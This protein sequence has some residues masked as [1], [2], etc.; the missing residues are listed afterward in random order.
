MKGS[1]SSHPQMC[2][3]ALGSWPCRGQHW[4]GGGE[5]M[6]RWPPGSPL[7]LDGVAAWACPS[8][9]TESNG[10]RVAPRLVRR[11]ESPFSLLSSDCP[12]SPSTSSCLWA[13]SSAPWPQGLSKG[14]TVSQS[15]S[16]LRFAEPR[17]IGQ[18]LLGQALRWHQSEGGVALMPMGS[19]GHRTAAKEG[20]PQGAWK[21]EHGFLPGSITDFEGGSVTFLSCPVCKMRPRS[22]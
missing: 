4:L 5:I 13:A 10:L 11:M 2:Q 6:G 21:Q 16:T 14:G 7:A 3:P 1:P 18:P 22:E 19:R 17:A 15:P 9:D 8:E 12:A 20:R